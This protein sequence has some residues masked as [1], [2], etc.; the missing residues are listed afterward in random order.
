MQLLNG[1]PIEFL[2]KLRDAEKLSDKKE[3]TASQEYEKKMKIKVE[4]EYY[5]ITGGQ[6]LIE[7]KKQIC[8]NWERIARKIIVME[9]N[10]EENQ[11]YFTAGSSCVATKL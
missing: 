1:K 3:N 10:T 9:I 6:Q 4:G 2:Y 7:E 11:S 5:R 8:N